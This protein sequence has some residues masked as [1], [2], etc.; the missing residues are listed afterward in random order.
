MRKKIL[1]SFDTTP[2]KTTNN[3]YMN[4]DTRNTSGKLDNAQITVEKLE[5]TEGSVN[6]EASDLKEFIEIED[7]WRRRRT[8]VADSKFSWVDEISTQKKAKINKKNSRVANK[9]K[10]IKTKKV[11]KNPPSLIKTFAKV[12]YKKCELLKMFL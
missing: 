8:T 12:V 11:I 9:H 1:K 5:E 10:Y 7:F 2:Y 3:Y 6:K 4:K